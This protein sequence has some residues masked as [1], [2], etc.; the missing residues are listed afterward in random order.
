LCEETISKGDPRAHH[1]F[2]AP[3]QKRVPVDVEKFSKTFDRA[4]LRRSTMDEEKPPTQPFEPRTAS[5]WD[6][7]DDPECVYT[8]RNLYGATV[9]TS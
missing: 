5:D 9:A 7:A 6:G 4:I 3:H 8:A 1:G 2:I